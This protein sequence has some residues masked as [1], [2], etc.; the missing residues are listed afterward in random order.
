[1][2]GT[3]GHPVR[4]RFTKRGK[5]RFVSHRDVARA[6]DRAF[7]IEQLPLAFT[8]GFSPR[9]KV[10]FGLALS[11]GHESDAEYLDVELID[12]VDPE[13]LIAP[14][15]AA[16]PDGIEVTGAVALVD[17]APA[18]QEAVTSVDYLVAPIDP[19]DEPVPAS[20]LATLIDVATASVELPVAQVR[21]GKQRVEDVKPVIQSIELVHDVVPDLGSNPVLG[22]SLS[23]QPRG[24]RPREVLDAL[25]VA[26]GLDLA[27]GANS[28]NGDSRS[29]SLFEG[30]VVRIAQ[31]IERNGARME[32]LEADVLART[33]EVCAS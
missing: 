15:T 28:E 32:P 5:V 2:R 30:R 11:V 24:A 17:R 8:E 9:P 25:G 31:W 6:F 13:G 27:D 14:L 33:P 4:L 22:L 21:K 23:T 10:S 1:V 29:G 19:H 16:L 20:V 18:L 12:V 7:R 26:A 3:D